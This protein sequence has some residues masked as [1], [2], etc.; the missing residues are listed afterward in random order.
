MDAYMNKEQTIPEYQQASKA[1]LEHAR[2]QE[3]VHMAQN[4]ICL[5][6]DYSSSTS[7]DEL[8]ETFSDYSSD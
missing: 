3:F 2:E 1:A 6:S 5:L 7:S 4:Y 8:S